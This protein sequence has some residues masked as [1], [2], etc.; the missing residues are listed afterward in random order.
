MRSHRKRHIAVKAGGGP[1]TRAVGALAVGA[2]A[3][4]GLALVLNGCGDPAEP[5]ASTMPAVVTA[6]ASPP[7]G[8]ADTD[9]ATEASAG[10]EPITYPRSGPGN[11]EIAG[12][13]D[14]T[15]GDGGKLLQYQVA[16]ERGINGVTASEFAA[17][18]VSTLNDPHSWAGQGTSRLQR[19]GPHSRHDFTIYLAT[20]RTRDR[21]CGDAARGAA[22]SYTSCNNGNS[23]VL[24]VARW[25]HGVPSYDAPLSVYRQ[26]MINHETGHQLGNQHELCSGQGH[27]A[28]VMEQQTL[29]LHGCRAN[30][31]PTVKGKPYNGPP[32]QYNDPVPAQS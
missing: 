13:N 22:D 32:G 28:P 4:C 10:A 24:N 26:Y 12:G 9:P 2:L 30:P 27:L 23:V 14:A 16:V 17:T 25:A 6:L 20:P 31:W 18:V 15:A 11:W 7:P 1:A 29:G 8:A 5:A 19:V 3:V 21:L